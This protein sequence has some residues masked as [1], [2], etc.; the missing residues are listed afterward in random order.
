MKRNV[1]SG[2]LEYAFLLVRP[3]PVVV[4][5][6]VHPVAQC[7]ERL[8]EKRIRQDAVDLGSDRGR[9]FELPGFGLGDTSGQEHLTAR[10]GE[11]QRDGPRRGLP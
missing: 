11:S 4:D 7:A 8:V 10:D 9:D 3:R 6:D 1:A 2:N 5:S